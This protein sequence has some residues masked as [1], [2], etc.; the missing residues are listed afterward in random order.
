MTSALQESVHLSREIKVAAAG[1]FAYR[2]A[3]LRVRFQGH[4]PFK[5]PDGQIGRRKRTHGPTM[6]VPRSRR[7]QRPPQR[8]DAKVVIL[9]ALATETCVST[10]DQDHC[11]QH[12]P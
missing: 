6:H 10:M 3:G 8:G 5:M 9:I 4:G 12:G 1:Y 11:E 2:E 7:R